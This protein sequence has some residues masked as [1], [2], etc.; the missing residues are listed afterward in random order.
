MPYAPTTWVNGGPPPIDATH[1][2]NIETGVS[3]APYGP[4]FSSGQVAVW[5]G[6]AWVASSI[7]PSQLSGY[8]SDGTKALL[9][10]GTWGTLAT[11]SIPAGSMFPFGGTGAPGGYLLCD[12][13]S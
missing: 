11:P 8:P 13:A 12:G 1:L 10:N 7:S 4:D 6:S 3:K 9:G 5:S 2:N